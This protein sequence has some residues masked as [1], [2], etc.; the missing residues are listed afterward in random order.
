MVLVSLLLPKQ[1][2]A[3]D[4]SHLGME[5]KQGLVLD[6]GWFAKLGAGE[7]PMWQRFHVVAGKW[8]FFMLPKQEI[9]S[10]FGLRN[11]AMNKKKLLLD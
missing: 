5:D 11:S 2:A 9:L 1:V 4:R 6:R 10:V 8:T 3:D 7:S